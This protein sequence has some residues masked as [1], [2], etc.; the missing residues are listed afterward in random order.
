MITLSFTDA[1]A[2]NLEMEGDP[3]WIITIGEKVFAAWDG[4]AS[5]LIEAELLEA[6]QSQS[7]LEVELANPNK[8]LSGA[9]HYGMPMTLRYGYG[10]QLSPAAQLP[11]AEVREKY[12]KS[13]NR[14]IKITGKDESTK[15]SGGSNKGTHGK[16]DDKEVMESIMKS[17]GLKL[18]GNA[19]GEKS[20]CG[21]SLYNE[22]DRAASY[23][24][25]NSMGAESGGG[26]GGSS[27]T[28][29]YSSEQ[30]SS[31]E[32]TE[33]ERDAAHTFSSPAGW[34]K[35]DQYMPRD[36]NKANNHQGRNSQAPIKGT[37]EL[38]GVPTLRAMANVGINDVGSAA[39]GTYYAK[40]VKTKISRKDGYLTTV[41]LERSG[42]GKGGVG[43]NPPLIMTA[44][45]WQKGEMFLGSR[46]SNGEAQA[47][48]TEGDR[49]WI[50]FEYIEKPEPQR[51]G[52]EKKGK[53]E[54]LDI[55]NRWQPTSTAD[56]RA[57]D[58]GTGGR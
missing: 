18:T 55:R 10:N 21:V 5:L 32:G 33:A 54:G 29:P 42:Y 34:N 9:F 38:R 6:E 14:T 8:M 2:A 26:S 52:G 17:R 24:L 41:E 48:F 22:S 15:L 46:P 3:S 1:M 37:L 16:G 49:H 40:S 13:K 35:I 19:K 50:N 11:V 51:G 4:D 45:I 12:P 39:S 20:P 56:Q 36:K 23:R 58:L 31:M 27:P 57:E 53:G 44:N 25:G 7:H 47:T 43:G 28:S 30:S